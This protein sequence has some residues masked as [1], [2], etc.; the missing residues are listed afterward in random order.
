MATHFN[1]LGAG[2]GLG[3]FT[4]ILKSIFTKKALMWREKSF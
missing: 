2:Y 1:F 3:I 4:Q